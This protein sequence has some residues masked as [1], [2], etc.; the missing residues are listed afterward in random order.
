MVNGGRCAYLGGHEGPVIQPLGA[1]ATCLAMAQTVA[2]P[3]VFG[4]WEHSFVV[5]R[6]SSAHAGKGWDTA[7]KQLVEA[8]GRG[9]DTVIS[10]I[11]GLSELVAGVPPMVFQRRVVS[12]V[13]AYRAVFEEIGIGLGGGNPNTGRI[14]ASLRELVDDQ[15][16]GMPFVGSLIMSVV[17]SSGSPEHV[18][19]RL[20]PE[21]AR[22]LWRQAIDDFEAG[23]MSDTHRFDPDGPPGHYFGHIFPNYLHSTC[24]NCGADMR[25]TVVGDAPC[26]SAPCR[27]CR[28]RLSNPLHTTD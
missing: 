25:W 17:T 28:G 18:V 22:S 23:F 8:P 27:I 14:D 4:H 10:E 2:W 9:W 21:W 1:C 12:M 6:V 5:A 19:E 15:V 13:A 20:V 16:G 7:T 24:A 11:S 26:P 3:E